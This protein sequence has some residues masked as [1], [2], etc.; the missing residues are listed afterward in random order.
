VHGHNI[1]R[2]KQSANDIDAGQGE[3][4]HEPNYAEKT[5]AAAKFHIAERPADQW[6]R[7]RQ[8][9]ERSRERYRRL[10]NKMTRRATWC[11]LRLLLLNDS[12]H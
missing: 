8:K 11:G 7:D 3:P 4:Q 5:D 12:Y 1:G 9:L 2:E 6:R 10:P